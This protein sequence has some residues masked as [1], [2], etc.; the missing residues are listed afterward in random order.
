MGF[1]SFRKIAQHA[2]PSTKYAAAEGY[3][4]AVDSKL[5]FISP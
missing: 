4:I 2:E 1:G 3:E 5:K